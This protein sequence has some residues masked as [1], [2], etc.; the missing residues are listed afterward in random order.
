MTLR[1]GEEQREGLRK[2]IADLRRALH[3]ER[4]E[5][6]AVQAGATDLRNMV[7][8]VEAERAELGRLIQEARQRIAGTCSYTLFALRSVS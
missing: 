1:A 5:K 8:R 7:K 3:E 2:E 6:E 4:Y